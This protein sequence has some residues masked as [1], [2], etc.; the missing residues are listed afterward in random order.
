MV[1]SQL[2]LQALIWGTS[3]LLV[4]CGASWVCSGMHAD[5]CTVVSFQ[6]RLFIF[7]GQGR[8]RGAFKKASGW[9][10][11]RPAGTRE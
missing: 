1:Q 2:L 11:Q 7:L 10:P 8:E 4:Q 5:G 6:M 3:F 9:E